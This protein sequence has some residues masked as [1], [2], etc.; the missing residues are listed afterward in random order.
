MDYTTLVGSE[1]VVG[2]IKY[3]I[4]WSRI[5]ADGIL[6]EAEK[7]IY[8]KLRVMEMLARADVA[9]AANIPYVPF[10]AGYLDPIHL[11]IPGHIPTII[12]V[13]PSRFQAGLGW[14]QTAVLPV[15]PP[16]R[17]ANMD[18][19]INFNHRPDQAYTAKMAFYRRPDALSSDNPTNFLTDRYPTLLRRVC[20]MFAAEARKEFDVMDRAE[21]KAM[22]MVDDIKVEGDLGL[23]GMEFDF[24]WEESA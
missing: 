10:P 9:I 15:A 4:N 6:D 2:S 24:N 13:D 11:G 5:D 21:I 22:A 8:S 19:Q 14:D 23:R 17:W 1:L 12:Y 3:W 7:W 16:T 18:R 20:L